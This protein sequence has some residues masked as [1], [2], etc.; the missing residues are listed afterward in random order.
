MQMEMADFFSSQL[1]Q[2]LLNE[3]QREEALNHGAETPAQARSQKDEAAIIQMF[4]EYAVK[5]EDL[6]EAVIIYNDLCF[7]YDEWIHDAEERAK[8]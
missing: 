1:G 6:Q 3:G 7:L 4:E 2:E 8:A 5:S